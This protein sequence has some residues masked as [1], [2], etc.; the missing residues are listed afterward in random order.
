MYNDELVESL[1]ISTAGIYHGYD[2]RGGD[3]G[4]NDRGSGDCGSGDCG[5]DRLNLTH[6]TFRPFTELDRGLSH[7]HVPGWTRRYSPR[8]SK[9]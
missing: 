4:Q 5:G 7:A 2:D 3:S 6:E 8:C 1:D 9:L